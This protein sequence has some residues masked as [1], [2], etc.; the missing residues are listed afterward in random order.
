VRALAWPRMHN[1]RCGER[2]SA[3]VQDRSRRSSARVEARSTPSSRPS[4]ADALLKMTTL[5]HQ[6]KEI[7]PIAVAEFLGATVAGLRSVEILLLVEQVPTAAEARVSPRLGATVGG[8]GGIEIKPPQLEQLPKVEGRR[9]DALPPRT[10]GSAAATH[11]TRSAGA[12]ANS[13]SRRTAS[14]LPTAKSARGRRCAARRIS[15]SEVDQGTSALEASGRAFECACCL[16]EQAQRF[17]LGRSAI[18]C[19]RGVPTGG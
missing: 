9:G 5:E 12:S 17:V 13:P 16:F 8:L 10:E 2:H 11:S 18:L 15:G 14:S 6:L 7:R 3:P 4:L 19:A 1:S